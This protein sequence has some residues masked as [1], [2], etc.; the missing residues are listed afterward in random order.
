M[1]KQNSLK[2]LQKVARF[3]KTNKAKQNKKQICVFISNVSPS[4]VKKVLDF[5]TTLP[6]Q[7]V[8]DK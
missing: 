4:K 3:K 7:L 8:I 1:Y 2:Q 6:L 5:S